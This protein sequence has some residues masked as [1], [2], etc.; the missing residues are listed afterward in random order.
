VA[1]LRVPRHGLAVVALGTRLHV[2]GGGPQP[3]LTVS[4]A[5]EV[6]DIA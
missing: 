6:F 1:T 2:I 4:P 3:G 5:H